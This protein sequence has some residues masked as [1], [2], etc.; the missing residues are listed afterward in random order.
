MRA[1]SSA[2]VAVGCFAAFV[3]AMLYG[4]FSYYDGSELTGDRYWPR[5]AE[6]EVWKDVRRIFKHEIKSIY[7]F[8]ES[9]ND[10]RTRLVFE[11]D[12]QPTLE[13]VPR[14]YACYPH[15]HLALH[16]MA[17]FMADQARASCPWPRPVSVGVFWIIFWT[18]LLRDAAL[19]MGT[20]DIRW[21][22]MEQVLFQHNRDVAI[23]PDGVYGMG[24]PI[25]DQHY[26]PMRFL[27]RWYDSAEPIDLVIIYTPN[28]DAIYKTWR[29][30]WRWVT[31]IR[32][33]SGAGKA[34]CSFFIGPWPWKPLTTFTTLYQP[35][36][37][38]D[39]E[40]YSECEARFLDKLQKLKAATRTLE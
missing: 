19:W 29:N 13:R 36:R 30:E 35:M 20:I 39:N 38:R 3:V 40:T 23:I 14:L 17:S 2:Q 21:R 10:Q 31:A 37:K 32:R 8:D 16:V 34:F 28:E 24:T 18:P 4:R 15:G 33:C 25:Y 5:F 6:L 1:C 7:V 11:S 12:T 26:K 9:T 22:T 27:R